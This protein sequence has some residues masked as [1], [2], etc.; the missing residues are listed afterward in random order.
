MFNTLASQFGAYLKESFI[1]LGTETCPRRPHGE[2][3]KRETNYKSSVL[4]GDLKFLSSL[5]LPLS[6]YEK[7]KKKEMVLITD[8]L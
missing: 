8:L 3:Y 5:F 6:F 2:L 4:L 1:K 7:E